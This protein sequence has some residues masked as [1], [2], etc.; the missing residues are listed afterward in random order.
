MQRHGCIEGRRISELTDKQ[1]RFVEE[2]L[3]DGNASAACVRAGYSAK[4]ANQIGPALTKKPHIAEQI[5]ERQAAL[6]VRVG[7]KA[8]DVV[9][10][11]KDSYVAAIKARQFSAAVRAAELL[12]KRHG[13]WLDRMREESPGPTDEQPKAR[14]TKLE[15]E[16]GAD[17]E[18]VDGEPSEGTGDS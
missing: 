7:E 8:E 1:R 15:A 12:G 11:L 18:T 13:M 3:I 10:M 16:L 4:T 9:T 6:L 2:Y 5:K 17:E 14:I